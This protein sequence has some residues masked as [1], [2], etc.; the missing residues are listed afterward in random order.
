MKKVVRTVWI[1]L[2]S[3]LAFLVACTSPKG[4][5]RAEKKQL[6]AERESYVEIL[7]QHATLTSEDPREMY[8]IKDEEVYLRLKIY[9]IDSR[10]GKKKD[11]LDHDAA[12][13]EKTNREIDSLRRVISDLENNVIEPCVYGPPEVDQPFYLDEKEQTRKEL[14]ER[15]ETLLQTIRRREG[16]CVYGSPEVI[17]KY[18]EET[19]RLKAEAAEI[20]KQ[21]DEL[22]NEKQ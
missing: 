10:L 12:Q 20:Q 5:T 18:G 8:N 6:K 21:L 22:D 16:A 4:L 1:S 19:R 11:I 3:G 17:Q 15:L 9:E 14:T 7:E 13:I 2:L